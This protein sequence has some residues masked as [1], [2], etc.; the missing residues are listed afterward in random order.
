[1]TVGGAYTAAVPSPKTAFIT[2][3]TGQDGTYL[4]RSLASDGWRVVGAT[5]DEIRPTDGCYLGDVELRTLDVRDAGAVSAMVADVEPDRIYNLAA[6]SSVAL[7]WEEPTLT[8]AVNTE[9]VRHLL[10]AIDDQRHRTGRDARLLQAS[11][12]EVRGAG[13]DSPYARSKAA[14]EDLVAEARDAG[15]YAVCAVLHNHES[16]LRPERFVTRKITRAA[17]EIARGRR[18]ELTLG[19]LDVSRD[20]GFAGDYV[21]ALRLLVEADDPVDIEIG[22]GVAHSL[23]DLLAVAFAAAGVKDPD[24]HVGHDPGLV[25]TVDAAVLVA[26]PEPAKRLLGWVASTSFEET[27]RHMVDV[28]LRRLDTG[29]EDDVSYLW[30][31]AALL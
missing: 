18:D 4:A 1:M 16:P 24:A 21:R 7:S 9:G 12:A 2:G 27:V 11:S 29:V 22:T 28:D 10:A 30:P 13:A 5:I 26:D 20:W 19:N 15:T 3:V 17:A 8:F 23:G 14:A 31:G 6:V 25:R